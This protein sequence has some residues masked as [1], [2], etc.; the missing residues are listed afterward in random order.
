M[1]APKRFVRP[2]WVHNEHH[3]TR[4]DHG[5][6]V[7][8]MTLHSEE[9]AE[10]MRDHVALPDHLEARCEKGGPIPIERRYVGQIVTA[11]DRHLGI[12]YRPEEVRA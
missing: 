5:S 8:V 4:G 11:L 2:N 3:S 9:A 6:T 7:T 1:S 10:W 12:T